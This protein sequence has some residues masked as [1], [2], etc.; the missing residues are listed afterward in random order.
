MYAPI[1]ALN[2]LKEFE[3][4]VDASFAPGFELTAFGE[5]DGGYPRLSDRIRPFARAT[6]SGST[7]AIWLL[8][9]RADLATRRGLS[10]GHGRRGP[11]GCRQHSSGPGIIFE[12]A[13]AVSSVG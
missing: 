3:D 1:P 13:G 7:Y 6:G 4:G 5:D 8:D 12:S 10:R 11:E 9:D 2:L